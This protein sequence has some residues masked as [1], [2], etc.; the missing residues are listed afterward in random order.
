MSEDFARPLTPQLPV[1]ETRAEVSARTIHE[2][3]PSSGGGARRGAASFRYVAGT[4][5]CARAGAPAGGS[6]A[7]GAARRASGTGPQDLYGKEGS[8]WRPA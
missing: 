1:P 8:A 3:I 5:A 6:L 2:V 7:R 4:M